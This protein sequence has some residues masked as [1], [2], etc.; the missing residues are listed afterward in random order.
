ML[1]SCYCG[2]I[3]HTRIDIGNFHK[4]TVRD[5]TGM[6]VLYFIPGKKTPFM[7][8]N[9]LYGEYERCAYMI[10]SPSGKPIAEVGLYDYMDFQ[11]I[12][13]MNYNWKTN[14][15]IYNNMLSG[16]IATS[17]EERVEICFEPGNYKNISVKIRYKDCKEEIYTNYCVRDTILPPPDLEIEDVKQ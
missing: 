5:L 7:H 4:D 6:K 9:N 1:Y 16:I 2:N 12:E 10:Y 15:S 8:I 14:I 3:E 11:Y 17:K 13:T